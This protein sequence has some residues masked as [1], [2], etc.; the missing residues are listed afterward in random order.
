MRDQVRKYQLQGLDSIALNQMED[1]L[2]LLWK[3][4]AK[5][6]YQLE[7]SRAAFR[8]AVNSND[9]LLAARIFAYAFLMEDIVAGDSKEKSGN[10]W[11]YVLRSEIV[12][13]GGVGYMFNFI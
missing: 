6:P 7:V 4:G 8:R 13:I 5:L 12:D 1:L 11:D 2:H 9:R 10:E 3:I